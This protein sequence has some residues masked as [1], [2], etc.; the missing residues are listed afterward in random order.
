MFKS[1]YILHFFPQISA[2][3]DKKCRLEIPIVHKTQNKTGKETKKKIRKEAGE[4]GENYF[5]N[6][7]F[8]GKHL[9]ARESQ[10]EG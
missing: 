5:C 10:D 3:I 9:P 4:T 8:R 6:C 2:D 1:I 7:I